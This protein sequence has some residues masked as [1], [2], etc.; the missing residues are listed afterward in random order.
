[1][2]FDFVKSRKGILKELTFSKQSGN[3]I[4]VYSTALGT[5]MFLTV[6]EDIARAGKDE[7]IVFHRYDMSGQRLSRGKVSIDEIQMVLPFNKLYR[8]RVFSSE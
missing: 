7:V 1:M 4:G 6:V 3:L 5:G 8:T 2:P